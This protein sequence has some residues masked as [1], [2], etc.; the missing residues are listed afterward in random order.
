MAVQSPEL[1]SHTNTPTPVPDVF[2]IFSFQWVSGKQKCLI[3]YRNSLEQSHR[4]RPVV[5]SQTSTSAEAVSMHSTG[6]TAAP[7]WDPHLPPPTRGPHHSQDIFA[8]VSS[9]VCC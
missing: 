3:P 5:I 4:G 9:C 2:Y 6:S 1:C 7:S 8:H